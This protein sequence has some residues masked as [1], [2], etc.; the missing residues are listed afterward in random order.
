[1]RGAWPPCILCDRMRASPSKASRTA[2]RVAWAPLAILAAPAGCAGLTGLSDLQRDDCA[3]G[4]D[5]SGVRDEG[6]LSDGTLG[7]GGEGGSPADASSDVPV[8]VPTTCGNL[9][10]GCCPGSACNAP[11]VC[12]ANQTCG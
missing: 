7:E 3:F 2:A 6:A 5:D 4:C 8:D 1:M 10:Q 11:L 12:Q 9:G